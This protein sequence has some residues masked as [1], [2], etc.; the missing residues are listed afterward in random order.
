MKDKKYVFEAKLYYRTSDD[1]KVK[2]A[3]GIFGEFCKSLMDEMNYDEYITFLIA[4]RLMVDGQIH[5]L[6]EDEEDEESGEED[7]EEYDYEK[8]LERVRKIESEL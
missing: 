8:L 6:L 4:T 3:I 1:N 2:G 7:D 5:I